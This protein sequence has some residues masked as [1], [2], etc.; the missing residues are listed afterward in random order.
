MY[1]LRAWDHTVRHTTR[2][3]IEKSA[4][5]YVHKLVKSTCCYDVA[6]LGWRHWMLQIELP[7]SVFFR[8]IWSSLSA[9]RVIAETYESSASNHGS[10]QTNYSLLQPIVL[11][12]HAYK[13]YSCYKT[14][15]HHI[16]YTEYL[17]TN[18]V[19]VLASYDC[20]FVKGTYIWLS[21]LSSRF[22][23]CTARR[24]MRH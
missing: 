1:I 11:K 24:T 2:S 19:R 10:Y 16:S 4:L 7:F 6:A 22:L 9:R 12:I 20:V 23:Y 15:T 21:H 8:S 17:A 18:F 13:L 3:I 14:Q 5:W